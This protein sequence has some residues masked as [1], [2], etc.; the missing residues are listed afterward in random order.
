MIHIESVEEVYSKKNRLLWYIIAFKAGFLNSAGFLITGKFVSHITGFGTQIGIA[1]G[2]DDY[3]FGAELLIIPFS[4][5]AG[6]VLVSYILDKRYIP[7][8]T[9]PYWK[10][11]AVITT[12]LLIIIIIGEVG[13]FQIEKS[14]DGDSSYN[15]IELFVIGTLCCICGMKNGLV[16]WA[17][18]GK[19]RVTHLTGMATD[20][21]LNL[22]RSIFKD[23]PSHRLNEKPIVNLIRTMTLISFSIGALVSAIIFTRVGFIGFLI[24]VMISIGMSVVSIID[25]KNRNKTH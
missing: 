5:I 23:W 11:Q 3:F 2:H 15:L 25:Y 21:G 12:L 1:L 19:I 16:T 24:P 22:L 14:F 8:E 4:F 18:Y 9:P 7:G 10:V 17:T 6:S 13:W 20:I